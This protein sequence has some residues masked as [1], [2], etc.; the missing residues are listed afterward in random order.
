M[1]LMTS[2]HDFSSLYGHKVQCLDP[3]QSHT[4]LSPTNC[5]VAD[6]HNTLRLFVSP[7]KTRNTTFNLVKVSMCRDKGSEFFW[8]VTLY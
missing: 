8:D 3:S 6:C 4:E 1:L 2:G 7:V 5:V